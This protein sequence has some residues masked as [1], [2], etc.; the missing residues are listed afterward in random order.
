MRVENEPP[1]FPDTLLLIILDPCGYILT[2]GSYHYISNANV[3]YLY[4]PRTLKS[5]VF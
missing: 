3:R 4:G 5:N 1:T 2:S